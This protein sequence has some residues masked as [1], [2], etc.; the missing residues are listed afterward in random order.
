MKRRKQ[1]P[2]KG[3]KQSPETLAKRAATR[4]ANKAAKGG[5]APNIKDA[6]IFLKKAERLITQKAVMGDLELYVLCAKRILEGG[7]K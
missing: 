6:L 3:R 5:Q 2:L 4:A 1:S 7:L